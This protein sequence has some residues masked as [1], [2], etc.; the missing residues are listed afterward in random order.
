M[1]RKLGLPGPIGQSV[2]SLTADPGIASL[3]PTGPIP[4]WRLVMK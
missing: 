3:T 2:A 4:S 1:F